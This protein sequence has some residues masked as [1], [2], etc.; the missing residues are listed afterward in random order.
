[1][2]V[3]VRVRFEFSSGKKK[4]V[5]AAVFLVLGKLGCLL[6]PNILGCNV[7]EIN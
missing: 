3:G 5:A 1:M 4:W 2:R 7:Q 6:I